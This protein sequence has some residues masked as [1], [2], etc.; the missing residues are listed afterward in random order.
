MV[1]IFL[2]QVCFFFVCVYAYG[3]HRRK[4]LMVSRPELLL[5][6]QER[7]CD[8]Y[9]SKYIALRLL[10]NICWKLTYSS[11]DSRTW[12]YI[13]VALLRQGTLFTIFVYNTVNRFQI[14]E[15]VVNNT[16]ELHAT[17]N[18][19]ATL[20]IFRRTAHAQLKLPQRLTTH[21]WVNQ[22]TSLNL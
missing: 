1:K 10:S 7:W 17:N 14:R 6:N 18:C 19:T 21:L 12:I 16:L 13:C 5:F 4:A 3:S 22:N 20:Y 2:S 9:A 8:L 11:W 15:G